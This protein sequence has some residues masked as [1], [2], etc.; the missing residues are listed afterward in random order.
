MFSLQ[1]IL[2]HYHVKTLLNTL[3]K[4]LIFL[5]FLEWVITGTILAGKKKNYSLCV[6]VIIPFNSLRQCFPCPQ[7]VPSIACADNYSDECSKIYR[8]LKFFLH[9]DLF[10]LV[11]R[12]AN[13]DSL[14]LPQIPSYVYLTPRN[15]SAPPEFSFTVPKPGSSPGTN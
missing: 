2:P 5:P 14:G 10:S 11:P 1:L 6:L 4:D 9:T 12:P 8:S 7:N 3:S 13:S 15:Y